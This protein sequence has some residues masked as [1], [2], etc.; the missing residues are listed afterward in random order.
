MAL[1]LIF[2]FSF[3]EEEG[4]KEGAKEAL[5]TD[6]SKHGREKQNLSSNWWHLNKC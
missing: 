6:V 1:N 3:E 2:L 4:R 5:H